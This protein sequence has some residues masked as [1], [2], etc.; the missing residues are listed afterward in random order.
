MDSSGT[1]N[2]NDDYSLTTDGQKMLASV[3]DQI[4]PDIESNFQHLK[5]SI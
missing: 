3:F 1:L 5:A 4:F 2:W